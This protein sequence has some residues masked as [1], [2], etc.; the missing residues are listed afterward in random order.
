MPFNAAHK[1]KIL[2]GSQCIQTSVRLVSLLCEF[3]KK[4]NTP[5]TL[6][7]RARLHLQRIICSI[8]IRSLHSVSTQVEKKFLR[9]HRVQSFFNLAGHFLSDPD[10]FALRRM[11]ATQLGACSNS[12]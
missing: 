6:C 4:K 11:K 12:L 1:I 2:A 10:P 3:K 5:P 7:T 9:L 8:R